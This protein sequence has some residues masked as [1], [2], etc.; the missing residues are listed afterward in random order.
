MERAEKIKKTKKSVVGKTK[1]SKIN[2]VPVYSGP[3]GKKVMFKLTS[4]EEVV[5]LGEEG[6]YY[7]IMGSGGE[8]WVKKI[9]IK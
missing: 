7:N 2:N 5:I 3:D 8:G 9:L 4:K 6:D 1:F